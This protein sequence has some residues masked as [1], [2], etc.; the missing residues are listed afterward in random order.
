MRRAVVGVYGQGQGAL[1]LIEATVSGYVRDKAHEGLF[2]L[3]LLGSAADV[4]TCVLFV[5]VVSHVYCA[6]VI[7]ML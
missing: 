1:V 5:P 2:D 7:S 3:R 4:C 6:H